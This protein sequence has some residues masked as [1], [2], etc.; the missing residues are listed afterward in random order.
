V[1]QDQDLSEDMK[2]SLHA[3]TAEDGR[4]FCSWGACRQALLPWYGNDEGRVDSWKGT[5]VRQVPEGWWSDM[6]ARL[7]SQLPRPSQ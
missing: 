4:L 1:L 2:Q 7:K 3:F 6:Y 5:R